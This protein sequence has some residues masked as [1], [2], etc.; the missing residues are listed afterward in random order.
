LGLTDF[1]AQFGSPIPGGQF[2]IPAYW[3]SLWNALAQ[4]CTMIGASIAGPF[5]DFAGRRASFVAAALIS[6]A[7][8]AVVY[9]A[10][11]PSVFL[12]GKM[13]NGIALGMCQTTGQTY[14]SEIAPLQMR[15]M[16][17]SIFTTSMVSHQT[18]LRETLRVG[19]NRVN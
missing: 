15:G 5:Q 16:A 9:T 8:V 10:T 2:L 1:R 12:A 18:F 3:Q 13:V 4:I 11:T 6:A 7:G 19:A 14:V 17:L